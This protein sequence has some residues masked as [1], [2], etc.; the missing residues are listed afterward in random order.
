MKKYDFESRG[1]KLLEGSSKYNHF[2][3]GN[4]YILPNCPICHSPLHQ[5]VSLDMND[6]RFC[7]IAN[8]E[9]ITSIPLISCLN[10]SMCWETQF[11]KL[12]LFER[13]IQII[14]Q[15]QTEVW[16]DEEFGLPKPLPKTSLKLADLNKNDQVL[17]GEWTEFDDFGIKYFCR[18]LDKIL[19]ED[20]SKAFKC[21]HCKQEMKFVASITEDANPRSL[22]SV[23]DFSLGEMILH[24]HFCSE[25]LVIRTDM[26]SS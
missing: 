1:Y 6:Q 5:I 20:K 11:F 21:I 14:R 13:S 4:S 8:A 18:L 10:C 12:N 15:I 22:I 17:E 7:E 2:F 3:G 19:I 26:E 25:C 16:K 9:E 23:I 24:F